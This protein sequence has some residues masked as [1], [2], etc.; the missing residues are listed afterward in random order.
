MSY[1]L[2]ETFFVGTFN[3]DGKPLGNYHI[4]MVSEERLDELL[5]ISDSELEKDIGVFS[6]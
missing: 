5:T 6:S 2:S 1:V 3:Y 4:E